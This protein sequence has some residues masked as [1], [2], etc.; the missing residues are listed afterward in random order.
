MRHSFVDNDGNLNWR[1]IGYHA[2]SAFAVVL[3]VAVLMAGGWF[4]Y[5]KVNEAWVSWRTADDY[6]GEGVDDVSVVVPPGATLTNIGDILVEN[7]VIKSTKTFREEAAKNPDAAKLQAG[8]YNLK[9]QIPAA[10]ALEMM[11]DPANLDVITITI[12]EGY[13]LGQQ[14]TT[15]SRE[16]GI[17]REDI[18]AAFATG[19]ITLPDWAGGNFEGFMFPDTYQVAEPVDPLQIAQAQVAQF[20]RVVEEIGLQEGAAALGLT[21]Y[22][23]IIVASI[24]E[25]EVAQAEYRPMVASVIYNRLAEGMKLQFDSTVHYATGN[26]DVVTTTEADRANPSPY[27]TYVHV[28]LPPGPISNPGRAAIEAALKPA[29]SNYLF[30]TTVD[31]DTGETRFAETEDGHAENVAAFQEW[32]Q[33]NTGRCV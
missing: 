8:R 15:V 12:P 23:V 13:T 11:L 24:I 28:G 16:L 3:S 2:R 27:N 33:A 26:F 7:D 19:K 21:P 30:F 6:I 22:Q 10:R 1:T 17:K 29:D 31:L 18:A 4:V 9:T 14:W 32:C 5:S 25:R 20:N